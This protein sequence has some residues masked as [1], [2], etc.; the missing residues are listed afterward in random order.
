MGR[1]YITRNG[2]LVIPA[3]RLEDE[4]VYRAVVRNEVGEVSV[5]I[6]MSFLFESSCHTSCFNDGTCVEISVCMCPAHYQGT[7]CEIE[8]LIGNVQ[9]Q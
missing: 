2:T 1:H 4:G 7:N 9:P 5:E 8:R 3:T 6:M